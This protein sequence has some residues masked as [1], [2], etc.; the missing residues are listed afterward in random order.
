MV[1]PPFSQPRTATG[2]RAVSLRRLPAVMGSKLGTQRKRIVSEEIVMFTEQAI[3]SYTVA[4]D[5]VGPVVPAEATLMLDHHAA[6]RNV[7]GDAELL[8]EIGILFLQEYPLALA[9]LRTAIDKRDPSC[10]ERMAHSLKG[11]VVTFGEGAPFQAARK[12]QHCG[13]SG[14]LM[15]VESDLQELE[16][17]LER[18]GREIQTLILRVVC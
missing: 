14:D 11:T 4:R 12:L 18:L 10:I 1:V 9:K 6:L 5:V 7:D 15:Q 2:M 13:R 8:R 16:Y 17:S 3:A